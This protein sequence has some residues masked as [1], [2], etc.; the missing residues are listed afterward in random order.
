MRRAFPLL[1]ALAIVALFGWRELSDRRLLDTPFEP[2]P[3]REVVLLSTAWCGYCAATRDFLQRNGVVFEELDVER[4]ERGRMLYQALGPS[5]VP[6]LL[7]DGEPIRGMNLRAVVRA[8]ER[9]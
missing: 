4:S 2:D 1:L 3:S 7:V 5:G 6:I 9:G 8:L